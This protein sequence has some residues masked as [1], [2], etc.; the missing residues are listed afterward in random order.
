MPARR[1][2]W[3][4]GCFP[5]CQPA[6]TA[7]TDSASTAHRAVFALCSPIWPT[8]PK[9]TSSIRAGSIAAALQIV[10]DRW[11]LLAVR[12]VLFGNHR[13][14]QIARNTGAPRD[15]LAARLKALVQAGVLEKREYSD[16]P[17]RSDYHLTRAGRELTPVLQALLEWGDKRA[18]AAPP[19][20]IQHHDHPLRSRTVCATC[21]QPVRQRDVRRVSDIPGWDITGPA[22]A[23]PDIS[24]R[25]R[26]E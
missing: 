20:A 19:I 13:F 14:S 4:A 25:T 24:Q 5:H 15:R 3:P 12:Q 23:G 6:V 17:P 7:G 16:T 21:G 2:G 1:S 10:G 22:P 8:V 26:P 18:V 9:I 11:S